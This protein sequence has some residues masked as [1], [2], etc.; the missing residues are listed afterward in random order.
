MD[1]FGRWAKKRFDDHPEVDVVITPDR[2]GYE[3]LVPKQGRFKR[4]KSYSSKAL[5]DTG[6][7]MTVIGRKVV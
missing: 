4:E 2:E 6:P 7:Q 1:E 3:E 5:A